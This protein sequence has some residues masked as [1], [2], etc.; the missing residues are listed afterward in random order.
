MATSGTV[1]QTVF[2]T[3]KVIDHAFRRAKVQPQQ[4]TPEYIET[5]LDLLFLNL[6][7]LASYG[8][9]LWVIEKTILPIYR[10]ERSVPL[11]VGSVDVMD[12]NIRQ[13]Q[14]NLG[15]SDSASE[16]IAADAFDQDLNTSLVQT[17]AGGYVQTDYGDNN[18]VQIDTYGIFFT[19]A[20]TE[21][22]DISIQ[23]SADGVT[24]TDL[25]TNAALSAVP[26]TWFWLD[27]EQQIP[28]RF[29]RL[30]A[31]GLTIL[32]LAEFYLGNTGNEI[33]MP[34]ISLDSYSNLPDKTF[35]SRPTE[36]WFDKQAAAQ[37]GQSIA[38]VWPNPDTEF[39]FYQYVLYIKR[40]IQD[41]GTMLQELE[42]PQRWYKYV[43]AELSVSV[44]LEIPDADI[45][46][47]PILQGDLAKEAKDAWTGEDDGSPVLL[48][49][50]IGV[51]T[52]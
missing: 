37:G 44:C 32:N 20:V 19:N 41:V 1:G 30:Q 42:V 35:L 8:I 43:I 52:R 47:L 28:N 15:N 25:Y 49:P 27:L 17:I 48:Q 40:Q 51:Y 10:G 38:T 4:I 2:A 5:A 13:L 45:T 23:S 36:Y 31:N 7:A 26:G 12:F 9:P 34:K 24:F 16:G 33:P 21:T 3:Q 18:A 50:R 6:S 11:P 22:W 14:R 46:R 39:T 29:I